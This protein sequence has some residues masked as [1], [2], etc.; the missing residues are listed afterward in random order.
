MNKYNKIRNLT[1]RIEPKL[2]DKLHYV[3]NCEGH[4]ANSQVLYLIRGCIKE[5][6]EKY[7]D[8]DFNFNENIK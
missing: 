7:G 4:S 6:E 1:V 8:I 3:S 5:C 2:L